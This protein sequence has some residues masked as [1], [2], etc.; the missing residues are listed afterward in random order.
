MADQ[1]QQVCK[2]KKESKALMKKLSKMQSKTKKISK[3]SKKNLPS[4]FLPVTTIQ[5]CLTAKL[6]A[7][8]LTLTPTEIR[9][10]KLLP[11]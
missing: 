2:Y 7:Q 8:L 5:K 3:M 10:D 1:S 9:E 6:V 11:K 4:A